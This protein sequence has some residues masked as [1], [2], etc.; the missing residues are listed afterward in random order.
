[1]NAGRSEDRIWMSGE[2]FALSE[3]YYIG[4]SDLARGSIDVTFLELGG[5]A[6]IGRGCD[7]GVDGHS[8]FMRIS[9]AR[10]VDGF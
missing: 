7:T 9:D 5:R 1:M 4:L 8:D 2:V 3:G 10:L 6:S